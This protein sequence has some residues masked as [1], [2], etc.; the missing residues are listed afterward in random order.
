MNI[1]A[2]WF[3]LCAL[4]VL[5][6]AVRAAPPLGNAP[7]H[8]S[9]DRFS[10]DQAK[11]VGTYEGQVVVTQQGLTL[12]GAK[13]RI[14]LAKKGGIRRLTLFGQPARFTDARAQGKP[15]SGQARQMTYTPSDQRI[16]LSGDAVV[17]QAGNTFHAARIVYD[18]RQ[19]TVEAGA[20][21]QRIEATFAPP[22]SKPAA[23]R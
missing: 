9:A 11:G 1:K 13:L 23:K 6:A 19:G 22:S 7:V 10:L 8:I 21:G 5:P 3:I 14:L 16:V 15:V 4:S 20:P 18:T 12:Y 17:E 2:T